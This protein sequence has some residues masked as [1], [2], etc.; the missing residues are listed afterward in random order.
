MDGN[1]EREPATD[2][3]IGIVEVLGLDPAGIEELLQGHRRQAHASGLLAAYD[4]ALAR[5]A[6]DEGSSLARGLHQ[7]ANELG[8]HL[9]AEPRLGEALSLLE[10][11]G[12]QIDEVVH[13]IE[14]R[15]PGGGVV[16][17]YRDITAAERRLAGSR[18]QLRSLE[19]QAARNASS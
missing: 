1:P 2:D 16:G 13:A 19:R 7:A 3:F 11:A 8:R 9:D 4:A 14:R 17:I 5:L 6:G 18:E 15:T 10:S 12:I